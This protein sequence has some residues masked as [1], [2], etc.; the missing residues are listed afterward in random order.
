MNNKQV[1]F[2]GLE[3]RLFLL[4]FFVSPAVC[5]NGMKEGRKP[6]C[7]HGPLF[8]FLFFFLFSVCF[9]C[10]F[11]LFPSFSLSFF[12][13][14]HHSP[15]RSLFFILSL[16]SFLSLTLFLTITFL[17]LTAF[18]LVFSISPSFRFSLAP[19]STS[20]TLSHFHPHSSLTIP[21]P[22]LSQTHS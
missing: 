3:M 5:E 11:E 20:P 4:F 12:S 19:F 16:S 22:L 13:F 2:L 7:P 8:F 9:C 15:I 6:A 1:R 17:L 14:F 21:A 18:L 10:F